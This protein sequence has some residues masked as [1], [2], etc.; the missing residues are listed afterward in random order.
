MEKIVRKDFA[1]PDRAAVQDEVIHAVEAN[2]EPFIA[3]YTVTAHNFAGRYVSADAFKD[4]FPQFRQS[5][6]ARNRYNTPVHNAAAVLA[7]EQYRRAIHDDS[8]PA[9]DKVMFVT[10]IPGA[11]KT[12][13]VIG[14]GFPETARVLFEGQL[15]RPEP[16]I[17]KMQEAIDLGL[18]V[19]IVAVHVTPELALRRTFQRF[20]EYGRGA[21]IAVM[22]DIQGGLPEGLRKIHDRFGDQVELTIFDNRIPGQ[23]K[24]LVGWQHL[25]QLDQEGNHDRITQR[26]RAELERHRAEGRISEA[27]YRQANG[28]APL[29]PSRSLVFQGGR[30]HERDDGQRAT[31]QGSGQAPDL[32]Q[33]GARAARPARAKTFEELDQADALAKHPELR[34]TYLQLSVERVAAAQ[35]FPLDPAAQDRHLASARQALQE[36]LDIGRIPPLPRAPAQHKSPGRDR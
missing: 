11:G 7:A 1:Q 18:K 26:L 3:E 21:G 33:G 30:S 23:H 35:K 24:E 31:A 16:S 4:T 14:A 10:G 8:D 9:R 17:Q 19:E 22:A 20:E 36:R 25:R 34:G 27:C 2:P 6:E 15:N 28:D 5:Q 12:S 29:E 13:T 32:G